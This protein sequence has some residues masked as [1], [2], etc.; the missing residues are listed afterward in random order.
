MK[1]SY[2]IQINVDGKK[3]KLP[4]DVYDHKQYPTCKCGRRYVPLKPYMR[5]CMLCGVKNGL[6]IPKKQ[7]VLPTPIVRLEKA[8]IGAE[9][10]VKLSDYVIEKRAPY[11]RS[12][13]AKKKRTTRGPQKKVHDG[14]SKGGAGLYSK[15]PPNNLKPVTKE[16]IDAVF[17]KRGM[18][19]QA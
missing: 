2:T 15:K 10:M 8:I 6:Y 7:K 4:P 12:V 18:T 1:P 19:K 9:T 16:E 3:I 5:C 17:R 14:C 11:V 13:K